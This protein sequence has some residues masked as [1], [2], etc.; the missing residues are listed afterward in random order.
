MS[1]EIESDCCREAS[2]YWN[3]SAS[4]SALGEEETKGGEPWAVGERGMCPE[5]MS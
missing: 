5:M 3:L 4:T 1:V 2:R